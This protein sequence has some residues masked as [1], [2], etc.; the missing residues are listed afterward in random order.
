[1]FSEEHAQYCREVE[2]ERRLKEGFEKGIAEAL[3]KA[4]AERWAEGRAEGWASC[5]QDIWKHGMEAVEIASLLRKSQKE[6]QV[7]LEIE[8]PDAVIGD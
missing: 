2:I 4:R 5:V 3:E 7:I 1:M 8:I 6:I